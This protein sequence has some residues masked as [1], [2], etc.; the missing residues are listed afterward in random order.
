[1]S[2]LAPFVGRF[3]P[4]LVHFPI[5]FLLLAGALEVWTARRGAA[6]PWIAAA[7]L[8]LLALA[9]V[10]AALA[11]AAGYL[12][13][14]SGGYGGAT[15][16]RHLQLGVVVAIGALLTTIAAWRRQ[17]TGAGNAIVRTGLALTLAAL[18]VAGH[19]GATLTHGEGYLTDVAPAPLRTLIAGVAGTPAAAAF[20]GPVER[21]PVYPA[22]V[23]PVLQRH[24][25]SCH[26]AGTAR[27]GLA[28]DTP[29]GILKGGD[30]GP[31]VAPG[32]GLGSELVRRVWLPADHPDVMPPRG[33]RPLPAA[34]A[35]LL[36]WWIDG[37]ASFEQ[38]L[39]ELDV[40]PDVLPVVER[41]LG[42]LA[43]GG[44]TIPQV[45]LAAPDP[46]RLA[47]IRGGG[48]D[49][50]PIAD[51]SPF[52]DARVTGREAPADGRVASLAPLAPHVLWL[53]LSDTATTD[54]AF[55]AIAKMTNVTRLD[56]SRTATTDRGLLALAP[57]AQLETLNL[58][59]TQVT[60]AGLAPLAAL[61]RLRRIYLWETGVTPAGV[62]RLRAAR[63]K[64]EI[65][66]G[67]DEIADA[68]AAADSGKAAAGAAKKTPAAPPR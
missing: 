28:L 26:T 34:D 61:P 59:G 60:D 50:R 46:A 7:R 36:R 55:P 8:P 43:R 40:P 5:A 45:S 29:E 32:R 9:A 16:D 62:E 14:T 27:G 24:C 35:G 13:G 18:T 3:H 42:A 66:L 11:A 33:Q 47:A 49:L 31:V 54:A 37:G 20:A 68:P 56:V 12:L 57:L 19:L 10:A 30:H 15:F 64:L 53:T 48:I 65:V 63:P 22:L 4:L 58:Y 52:L 44:P 17:R 1:M 39:A 6:S 67:D 23:R 25:V 21:A 51:G 41:R 38:P 2:D